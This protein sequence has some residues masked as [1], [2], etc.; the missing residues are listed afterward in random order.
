MSAEAHGH[1]AH[2][3]HLAHHFGTMEQ[4]NHAARLGMWLFL[5]TEVLLFGDTP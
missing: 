3:P 1:A 5:A 2:N 4:Q